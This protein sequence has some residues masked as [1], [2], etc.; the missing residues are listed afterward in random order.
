MGLYDSRDGASDDGST[1]QVN[2]ALCNVHCVLQLR[3]T[4]L[5]HVMQLRD[6]ARQCSAAAVRW[7]A[8]QAG[9]AAGH[10]ALCS[11][12]RDQLGDAAG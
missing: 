3:N 9:A 2:S 11:A 1:A 5:H 8:Q 7:L 4:Q 6:A 12:L 10:L